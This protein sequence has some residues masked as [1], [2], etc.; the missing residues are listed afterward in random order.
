MFVAR[1]QSYGLSA[2]AFGVHERD[3]VS[4]IPAIYPVLVGSSA[5]KHQCGS[6]GSAQLEAVFVISEEI[7][8]IFGIVTVVIGIAQKARSEAIP[9]ALIVGL[10]DGVLIESDQ[11]GS[12][13]GGHDVTVV[14]HHLRPAPKG[15]DAVALSDD[16]FH[17]PAIQHGCWRNK[18][19]DRTPLSYRGRQPGR[20]VA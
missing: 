14:L 9:E 20:E 17:R 15:L 5:G 1:F 11:L 3:A 10:A 12:G 18:F 6:S 8:V 4:E 2:V 13:Y 7:V 16:G 19:G